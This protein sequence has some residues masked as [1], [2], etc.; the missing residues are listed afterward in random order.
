MA[1]SGTPVDSGYPESPFDAFVSVVRSRM[2]ETKRPF[3]GDPASVPE[4]Y[5]RAAAHDSIQ[6]QDEAGAVLFLMML[7]YR[8]EWCP[9]MARPKSRCGCPDCFGPPTRR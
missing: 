3:W 2:A 6:I 1:D 9:V 8:R 7:Y 4:H 5:L